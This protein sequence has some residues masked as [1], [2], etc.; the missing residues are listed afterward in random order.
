EPAPK[1]VD[2]PKVTEAK[3]SRLD[4][5]GDPLPE[6]AVAR[7]G[8]LRFRHGGGHVNRLLISPDGKTLISKS[9][10]GDRTVCVWELATGKL[11]RQFPG[12]WA[13][14][15]AVALSPDGKELAI[16]QDAVIH[17]YDLN[18][19]HELRQIKSP[20]GG[21]EGLAFSPDGKLLASGHERQTVIFWD[22]SSTGR[23]WGRLAA[24]HNSLT[25]L[26]FSPDGKTLAAS[27]PLDR[28][29]RL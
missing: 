21:T 15:G 18:S 25:M 8:T 11:L 4:R 10:Y 5:Y 27:S 9:Y 16:G 6:G 3:S 29:I 20:L 1:G 22:L 2:Q 17:F 12:H 7:L 24:K 28:T 19:G 14:N 26:T 13:E 23:E